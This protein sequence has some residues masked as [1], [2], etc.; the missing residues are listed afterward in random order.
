LHRSILSCDSSCAFRC[1]WE[2]HLSSVCGQHVKDWPC[3]SPNGKQFLGHEV[4]LC[5]V[6]QSMHL[7]GSWIYDPLPD[8][9]HTTFATSAKHEAKVS[10][11]LK[12]LQ[13]P[14]RGN[15]YQLARLWYLLKRQRLL[16][17]F[18]P[19]DPQH[20]HHLLLPKSRGLQLIAQF[21]S[22]RC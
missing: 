11:S 6:A 7:H 14:G 10:Y 2:K 21:V 1:T 4:V 16:I 3:G 12:D 20:A 13:H 15:L 9:R 22:L 5:S 17:N 8:N 18:M 19:A